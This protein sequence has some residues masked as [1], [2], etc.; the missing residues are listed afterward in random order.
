MNRLLFDTKRFFDFA[1][2]RG[3]LNGES[4]SGYAVHSLLGELFQDLA[5]KPF[6]ISNWDKRF[7]T[8]LFYSDSTREDFMNQARLFS[9]PSCYSVVDWDRFDQKPL[10]EKWNPGLKLG[11]DVRVCPVKRK[12][13]VEGFRTQNGA[14]IDA[15]L[16]YLENRDKDQAIQTRFQ[17]YEEWVRKQLEES[18]V[19]CLKIETKSFKLISL[20]RRNNER[21]IKS[22]I[23]RPEAFVNGVIE[24]INPESFSQ[25][26]K[27]GIG[28]HR[29]FGFGMILLKSMKE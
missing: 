29:A 22:Y 17:V 16:S 25:L 7:F 11:F 4:D 12:K 21:E 9:D 26:M 2:R 1:A 19:K 13:A 18:E 6:F 28:R 23:T 10:P 5:P 3:L 24:I 14:E 15:Y 20:Q 8:L 27:R